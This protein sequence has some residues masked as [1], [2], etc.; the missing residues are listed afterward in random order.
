[1]NLLNLAKM[2]QGALQERFDI[3]M[4]KVIE[5]IVDRNT[6]EKT[7]RKITLEI[8]FK[9]NKGRRTADVIVNS[10][11]TLARDIPIETS[12]AISARDG[13][14]EFRQVSIDDEKDEKDDAKKT[15]GKVRPMKAAE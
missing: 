1:M 13:C 15:D 8:T 4:R 9:P 12:I 11:A 5:N 10:R 14:E 6:E 3:E 7:A 2:A